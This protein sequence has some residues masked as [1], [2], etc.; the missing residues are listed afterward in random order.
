VNGLRADFD[1][2]G[3]P[4]RLTM[5]GQGDKNPFKGRRDKNAGALKKHISKGLPKQQKPGK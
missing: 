5:R 3:T 1:M 2:P 4:I